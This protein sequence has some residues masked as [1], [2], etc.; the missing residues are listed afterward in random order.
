MFFTIFKPCNGTSNRAMALVAFSQLL[1]GKQLDFKLA[2][3]RQLFSTRTHD[4]DPE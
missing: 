3:L 4:S 2:L 1:C